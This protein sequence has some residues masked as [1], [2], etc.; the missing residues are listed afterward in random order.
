[1]I[2]E[3]LGNVDRDHPAVCSHGVGKHPRK[4]PGACSNVGNSLPRLNLAGGRDLLSAGVDLAAFDLEFAEELLR[5][6]VAKRVVDAGFHTFL[7]RHA[8]G[9]KR[10]RTRQDD[11]QKHETTHGG[12]VLYSESGTSDR[13]ACYMRPFSMPCQ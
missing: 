9:G 2:E 8:D 4:E 11:S 6:G 3:F 13:S 10:H 12:V 7:L 5:V 1:V